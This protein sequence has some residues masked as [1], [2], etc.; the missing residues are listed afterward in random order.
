MWVVCVCVCVFGF[1][2]GGVEGG[3]GGRLGH[4]VSKRSCVLWHSGIQA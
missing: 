3:G 2:S 1:F 4:C